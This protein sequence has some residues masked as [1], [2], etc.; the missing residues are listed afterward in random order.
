VTKED[1]EAEEGEAVGDPDRQLQ[2]VGRLGEERARAHAERLAQPVGEMG[3]LLT[4]P[5]PEPPGHH[6]GDDGDQDIAD[7][8]G[9]GLGAVGHRLHHDVH[10]H[11]PALELAPRQ[12]GTDGDDAAQLHQFV[13]AAHGPEEGDPVELPPDDRDADHDRDQ[14]RG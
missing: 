5:G 3:K 6:E 4:E 13:V 2:L 10:G 12:E 14:T 11:M 7:E 1:R 9:E 8:A